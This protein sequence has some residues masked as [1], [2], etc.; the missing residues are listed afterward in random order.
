MPV[1]L[2]MRMMTLTSSLEDGGP[3][4]LSVDMTEMDIL[5]LIFPASILGEV[6]MDVGLIWTLIVTR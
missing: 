1:V 3:R 5:L 6:G 2:L 4:P